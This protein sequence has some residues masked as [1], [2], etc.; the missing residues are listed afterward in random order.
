LEFGV[1]MTFFDFLS[2]AVILACIALLVWLID[3]GV[4]L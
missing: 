3:A 1:I 2:A 4:W